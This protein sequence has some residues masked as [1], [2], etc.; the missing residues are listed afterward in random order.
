[1]LSLLVLTSIPTHLLTYRYVR[2]AASIFSLDEIK[3]ALQLDYT[4]VKWIVWKAVFAT[5]Y[6]G[7]LRG[8]ELRSITMDNVN[9]DEQGVWCRYNQGKQKG[10]EKINQFL[11]PF[12]GPLSF[13][14]Y[15]VAYLDLRRS[16]DLGED[17]P[18]FVRAC[19]SGLGGQPM[20]KNHVGY[21]SKSVA[22]ELGLANPHTYT[23]HAFRRS[24]ATVAANSGATSVM[25][26]G[27]FGWVQ[28]ATALKYIDVTKERPT[29][30]AELLTDSK[31]PKSAEPTPILPP[32]GQVGVVQPA[33]QAA[34]VPDASMDE[35]AAKFEAA[36]NL[37]SMVHSPPGSD[38]KSTHGAL[39]LAL[40]V[41]GSTGIPA[42]VTLAAPS[43]ENIT[44]KVEGSRFQISNH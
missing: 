27:Q 30:M 3:R 16:S 14:T 10:E 22:K 38:G 18:L 9:V 12:G 42:T 39:A 26:K 37:T 8:I 31:V 15:L 25:M 1:M 21:I 32:Q 4:S 23:G 29:K 43:G 17:L 13:G 36:L 40:G 41:L 33:M 20:G 34:R 28:E 35:L 6:C 19:K 5:A 7:G 24:A 2:K 11:V 44:I